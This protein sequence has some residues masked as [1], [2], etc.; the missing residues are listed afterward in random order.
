LSTER[1]VLDDPIPAGLNVYEAGN[2]RMALVR[3]RALTGRVLLR[4]SEMTWER[5]VQGNL[6]YYLYDDITDTAMTGWRVFMHRIAGKSG[7]HTHQGGLVIYVLS[8]RGHT[9]IDG[10]RHDWKAGDLIMLPV[11]PGGVEHQHFNDADEPSEWVAFIHVPNYVATGS[12]WEQNE[13][14]TEQRN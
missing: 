10:E 13:A 9:V 7:R 12:I 3:D 5:N 6:A 8:G 2:A 1:Q 4:E 14:L 11:V